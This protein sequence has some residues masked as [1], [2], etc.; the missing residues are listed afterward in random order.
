MVLV[1][2]GLDCTVIHP[3]LNLPFPICVLSLF[4]ADGSLL[5]PLLFRILGTEVTVF[6]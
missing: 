3:P 6:P 4:Q 5:A 2:V 1:L